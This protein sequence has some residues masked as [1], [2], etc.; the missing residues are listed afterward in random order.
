V[1][2]YTNSGKKPTVALAVFSP[3]YEQVGTNRPEAITPPSDL[4]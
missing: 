2:D 3:P 1:F 4:R